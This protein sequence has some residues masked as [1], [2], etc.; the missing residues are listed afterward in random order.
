[1]SIFA[2]VISR[3][4][5]NLTFPYI[6]AKAVDAQVNVSVEVLLP[7]GGHGLQ[8][9]CS[10]WSAVLGV[11]ADG[12]PPDGDF[13][14][15]GDGRVAARRCPYRLFA[16]LAGAVS[17]L[18]CEADNELRPLR[19]TLAPNGMIMKRLRNAGKARQRSWVGRCGSGRRQPSTA[20]MSSA[21]WSSRPVAAACRWRSGCSPV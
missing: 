6:C 13:P 21:V 9:S 15:E 16:V 14:K 10:G 1:M 11:D 12:G 17:N 7:K 20:A 4:S 19:Q 3:G 2:L 8:L 5:T 18:I